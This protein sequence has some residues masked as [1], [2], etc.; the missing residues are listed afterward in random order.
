MDRIPGFEP[1]DESSNLSWETNFAIAQSV[2]RLTLIQKVSGST[3]DRKT[4][5]GDRI[6]TVA[7]KIGVV[8]RRGKTRTP[9]SRG[10][11]FIS[12]DLESEARRFESCLPDKMQEIV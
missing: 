2:E 12:S 1:G 9:G 6:P 3:P 5:R 8:Y 11:R 7:G 10:V 4:K